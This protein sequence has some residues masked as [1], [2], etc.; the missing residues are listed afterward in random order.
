MPRVAFWF[1]LVLTMGAAQ[2]P[3]A[4]S[5]A[6]R[7]EL[8]AIHPSDPNE[9][10]ASSGCR[11]TPGL[12]RCTNVTLKRCIV[13]A[14][15]VGPGRVLGGPRWIDTD[16]F[17][18][19]GR[20]DQPVNDKG[21]MAMLETSLAERFHLVLHRESRRVETMVL[22]IA[23]KGARLQPAGEARPSWKNIHDHIDATKITMGEFAEI[24]SR[25]LTLPVVDRTGLTGAFNLRLRWNPDPADA[26]E[27][28]E[29]AGVLRLEM[30]TAIERQLGLVL[31][32]QKMPAGVL[33]IDHAEKPSAAE[34]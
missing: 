33:V 32:S 31:K 15:G 24:L 19:T 21:L 1:A 28:D 20:A 25:D 17:N 18:I 27:R 5:D 13:G 2:V 22:Q 16:R 23:T 26:L 29:A 10:S 6:P 3:T 30:S 11:T 8:D 12:M 14:Y 4:H 9:S 7:F 34:N